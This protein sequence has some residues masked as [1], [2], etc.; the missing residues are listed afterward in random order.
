MSSGVPSRQFE[1]PFHWLGRAVIAFATGVGDLCLFGLEMMGGMLFKPLP[2]G[3]FWA[4]MYRIGVSSLT[5][6]MI[7]GGFIGMVLA[8]QTYDQLRVM[9]METRLGAV[10]NVTLFKELGPVLAATMLAGRVGSAMA[11]ELATMRVTEQI[12]ALKALGA[13]PVQYLAVPRLLASLLLIPALTLVADGVGMMSGWFFSTQALGINS[14][15]YWYHTQYFVSIYDIMTGLVKSLFFGCGIAI[16][17]CHRGFRAGSG[18]EGV[19]RAATESFVQSFILILALDFLLGVFM[20]DL[21]VM[22]WGLP[23]SLL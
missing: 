11:A 21:Y 1:T 12:D 10:V 9:K 6:V 20:S 16:V 19:G 14:F 18:A 8:V 4:S 17:S 23:S 7:T 22:L 13:N 5:V 15:H 2:P 3:V